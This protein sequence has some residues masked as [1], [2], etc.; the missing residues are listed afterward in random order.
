MGAVVETLVVATA[1]PVSLQEAKTHLR[2]TSTSDDARI[3]MLTASARAWVE[4]E[5]RRKL[6]TQTLALYLDGFPAWMPRMPQKLPLSPLGWSDVYG[7]ELPFGPVQSVSS[8]I[9]FDSA[10]E[11]ITLSTSLYDV[12]LKSTPAR[13]L[14]VF[15]AVWPI[16]YLRM[17]AV[18]VTF[19]V[20]YS[21]IPEAARTAILLKLSEL[22]DGADTAESIE[23][24]LSP[25][26]PVL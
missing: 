13:I 14:P 12:D 20:G 11:P 10:N 19:V 22:Y 6:C 3:R 23:S 2:V 7:I 24:I 21:V 18:T 16:T 9:Y 15:G 4:N 5:T 1:E 17:N 8:I 25:L 26:S